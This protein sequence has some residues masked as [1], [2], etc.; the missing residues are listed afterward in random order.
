M[1]CANYSGLP[2]SGFCINELFFNLDG[3]E[4]AVGVMS[5][6][7]KEKIRKNFRKTVKIFSDLLMDL[8]R[9]SREL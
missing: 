8:P 1:D 4:F 3:Y 7:G 5:T 2:G 9:I 6:T